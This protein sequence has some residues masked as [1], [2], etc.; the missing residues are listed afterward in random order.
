M[1]PECGDFC[2][3]CGDCLH[4]YWEDPCLGLGRHCDPIEPPDVEEDHA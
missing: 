4:C 3:V 1:K 2:E